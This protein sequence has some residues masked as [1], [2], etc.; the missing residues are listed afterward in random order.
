MKQIQID[1]TPVEF[2]IAYFKSMHGKDVSD[3][4]KW[5]LTLF[6]CDNYSVLVY[7]YIQQSYKKVTADIF[8]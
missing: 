1:K 2:V 3:L 6:D 4:S 5:L 8:D 7:N